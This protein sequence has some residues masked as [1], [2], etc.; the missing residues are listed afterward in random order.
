MT[1]WRRF[2]RIDPRIVR[3]VEMRFIGGLSLET[4]EVLKV[5]QVTVMRDRSMA[6]ASYFAS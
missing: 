4:V 6:K 1:P 3:A 5:S 2:S